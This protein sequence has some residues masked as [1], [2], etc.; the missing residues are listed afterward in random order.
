M[1]FAASVNVGPQYQNDAGATWLDKTGVGTYHTD[2]IEPNSTTNYNAFTLLSSM[3]NTS[4][5]GCVEQRPIPYDVSDDPASTSTPGTMFVPLFAPDE[6]DNWTASTYSCSGSTYT[7]YGSS[8]RFN[9]A[10][11]GNASYNNYLPDSGG[12]CSTGSSNWTCSSGNANCGGYGIGVSERTAF[13]RS[14][15]YGDATHKV[16]PTSISVG[17]IPGGPNFMCTTAAVTPLTTSQT[18]ITTAINGMIAE[19]A[20]NIQAGLMW[21]WRLLSSTPPFT[22][23]RPAT[24]NDNQKIII[25][26]TDGENTYYPQSKF[27][28]SW[29]AA[30]GYT[31]KDHLEL[32]DTSPSTTQIVNKMNQRTA[33][34]CANAKA[35]GVKIYTVAFTVTDPDTL[36]MLTTCA[37]DPSMA[38]QSSSTT[39]LLAAFTAIGDDITLLRVSR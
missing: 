21:G 20:T 3:N 38:F 23:G 31:F 37:S 32:N 9:C 8:L 34:A 6:P 27:V 15:K 35:A 29:Y 12:T 18:T 7:G 13:Q 11:G 30:W 5:G 14:C 33:L 17:G 16:T 1:P 25:L 39:A 10:P 4:W 26:M 19:G 24:A 22:E 28:G 2:L 36:A